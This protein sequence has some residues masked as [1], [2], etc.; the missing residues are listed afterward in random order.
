MKV[1]EM[2]EYECKF[3][4]GSPK[5]HW[6]ESGGN[7]WTMMDDKRDQRQ[8]EGIRRGPSKRRLSHQ[9]T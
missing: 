7:G 6:T 5:A 9:S 2:F 8:V 1:D 4:T 3:I